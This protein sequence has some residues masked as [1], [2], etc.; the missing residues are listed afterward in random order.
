M[1]STHP[2]VPLPKPSTWNLPRAPRAPAQWM[3]LCLLYTKPHRSAPSFH[4]APGFPLLCLLPTSSCR[5]TTAAPSHALLPG[6]N[7]A[8]DDTWNVAA[9]AVLRPVATWV[10]VQGAGMGLAGGALAR[11]CRAV[12]C[13]IESLRPSCSPS[14]VVPP[15]PAFYS[16]KSLSTKPE[17]LRPRKPGPQ[18][19]TSPGKCFWIDNNF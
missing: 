9:C 11:G 6:R 19:L 10:P 18:S 16:S 8:F 4:P 2:N 5:R 7:S 14:T 15:P 3:H 12:T 17:P 1:G 13:G